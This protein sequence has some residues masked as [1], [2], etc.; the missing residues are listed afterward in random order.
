MLKKFDKRIFLVLSTAV[1][2]AGG[3]FWLAFFWQFG[4]I[5]TVSDNI[6]KEQLDSSVRQ[7]RSQKILEIGKELGDVEVQKKEMD[8]ML[9]DKENAVPFLKKLE[10]IAVE[11]N[12]AIKISVT[13]LSKI[14]PQA[15]KKPVVQESDAES[16]SE[17]QKETQAQKS[18]QPK[19][20][21]ADFSNQLGFSVELTG[22]FQPLVDFF[23]KL[24]NLPYFVRV[25][26]FQIN[27]VVAIQTNQT[28]GSGVAQASGSQP[29]DAEKEN[30]NL[31][32]T[33]VIGVYTNGKK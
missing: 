10:E 25:Y 32:S 26:N 2:L 4:K 20:E 9:I 6:Q 18:A 23:T 3:L 33:I 28:A 12:T 13:D 16:K 14:K 19:V 15:A 1:L 24:E 8:A 7:E 11:T 22:E 17:L 30:K 5:K 31:K 29:A 27:P 21:Q